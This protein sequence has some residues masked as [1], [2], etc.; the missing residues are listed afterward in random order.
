MVLF[1]NTMINYSTDAVTMSFFR[2]FLNICGGEA[3]EIIQSITI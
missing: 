3:K 1:Y 2:T